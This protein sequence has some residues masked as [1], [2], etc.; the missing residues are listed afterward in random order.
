ME[1]HHT[2]KETDTGR[3]AKSVHPNG[4]Q[5]FS[6]GSMIRNLLT[7]LDHTH[8]ESKDAGSACNTI[9]D[10][11]CEFRRRVDCGHDDQCHHARVDECWQHR[12]PW[13]RLCSLL[14][15]LEPTV[16]PVQSWSNTTVNPI[17]KFWR[18]VDCG[19]TLR[20]QLSY[21]KAILRIYSVGPILNQP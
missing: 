4:V 10:P 15:A 2:H 20:P 7:S 9:V 21:F 16:E 5:C 1:T 3:T 6:L 19:R 12:N 14:A 17:G 18:R 11:V 13:S 8:A